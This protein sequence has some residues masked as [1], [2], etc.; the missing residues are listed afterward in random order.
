MYVSSY[1]ELHTTVIA[2]MLYGRCIEVL[3]VS[4][5]IIW[6]FLWNLLS[7]SFEV[8]GADTRG[9][10]HETTVTHIRNTISGI[11]VLFTCV[12]PVYP[13]QPTDVSFLAPSAISSADV[14]TVTAADDTTTYNKTFGGL[15]GAG[16]VVRIPLWWG[17]LHGLSTG[18]SQ[19]LIQSLPTQID[20]RLA[21]VMMSSSNITSQESA[22]EYRSFVQECYLPAQ[23]KFQAMV[24]DGRLDLPDGEEPDLDWAGSRTLM[25]MPGGYLPC[26]EAACGAMIHPPKNIAAKLPGDD[27][28]TCAAWW[29]TIEEELYQEDQANDHLYNVMVGLGEDGEE[30]WRSERNL[31]LPFSDMTDDE[32]RVFRVKKVLTSFAAT[33]GSTRRQISSESEN[34]RGTMAKLGGWVGDAVATKVL[35]EKG[36]QAEVAL[37]V[38]KQAAPM[39]VAVLQ[40]FF[41][42]F[43]P[44]GLVFTL[45]R[46]GA[47]IA[48]SFI[49]FSLI[50]CHVLFAIAGWLDYYLAASLFDNFGLHS[51]LQGDDHLF[52]NAQKRMLLNIIMVTTYTIVPMFWM[53]MMAAIGVGAGQQGNALMGSSGGMDAGRV[54]GSAGGAIGGMAKSGGSAALTGGASAVSKFKF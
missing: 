22:L 53:I 40:L 42:V 27:P 48:M 54:G 3:S 16:A 19:A 26:Y 30:V 5:L 25:Q 38:I 23:S 47:V 9:E 51:W 8:V 10:K 35:V 18:I 2:W 36:L 7:G 4:S 12:M 43:I 44:F 34:R 20:L 49:M 11:V 6:P 15:T 39:L 17:L 32:I 1:L 14:Q 24:T 33:Q 31:D 28:A 13:V 45:Y 52:G 29:D 50:F 37:G 41:I 46:P 21:K